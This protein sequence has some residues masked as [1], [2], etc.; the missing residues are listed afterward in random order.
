MT[1]MNKA[2]SCSQEAP[3]RKRKR[4][5]NTNEAPKH[6]IP[7]ATMAHSETCK[8]LFEDADDGDSVLNEMA[9]E[10]AMDESNLKPQSIEPSNEYNPPGFASFEKDYMTFFGELAPLPGT[11]V[12]GIQGMHRWQQLYQGASVMPQPTRDASYSA[13]QIIPREEGEW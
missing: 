11:L 1:T 9:Q 8:G 13:P 2:S 3:Y 12:S 4:R 6:D 10:A 5:C 7:K